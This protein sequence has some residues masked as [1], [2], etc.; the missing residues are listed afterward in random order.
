M[1]HSELLHLGKGGIRCSLSALKSISMAEDSRAWGVLLPQA[2]EGEPAAWHLVVSAIEPNSWPF[3]IRLKVVLEQRVGALAEAASV[4][5]QYA[6]VLLSE[7]SVA[8]FDHAIWYAVVEPTLS[9]EKTEWIERLRA[10]DQEERAA[11]FEELMVEMAHKA[12]E[13]R[14]ALLRA[15]RNAHRSG[16]GG[17]LRTRNVRRTVAFFDR[18]A[19]R[20]GERARAWRREVAERA[21]RAY[22]KYLEKMV[23]DAEQE[24]LIQRSLRGTLADHFPDVV[25]AG[26][27]SRMASYWLHAAGHPIEFGVNR[28]FGLVAEDPAAFGA[29]VAKLRRRA[30]ARDDAPLSVL[31]A[32]HQRDNYLRIEGLESALEI[33]VEYEASPPSSAQGELARV[34]LM[35]KDLQFNAKRHSVQVI[36]RSPDV[37]RGL[38]K[39]AGVGSGGAIKIELEQRL[40][41]N[42]THVR[43]NVHPVAEET[44][45]LSVCHAW[46]KQHPHKVQIVRDAA[47]QR[48]FA[49]TMVETMVESATERVV[50]QLKASSIV[51]QVLTGP[52]DETPWLAGEYLGALVLGVPVVRIRASGRRKKLKLGRDQATIE[53]DEQR[54]DA[55]HEAVSKAL[56]QLSEKLSSLRAGT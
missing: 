5:Q 28:S 41:A 21:N 40:S 56:D 45:F 34:L 6:N 11:A 52:V 1:I 27:L 18:E 23:R 13:L 2:T 35:L 16:E 4:V 19:R 43:V 25:D 50:E 33:S 8:G 29:V 53:F 44:L 42:N 51:L 22:Q 39:F 49:V 15:S 14:V 46:A 12:E 20:L 36:Q 26:W 37:E 31:G 54:D 9:R 30:D 17:F 7:C 38:M 10:P 48:A 47:R 32:F 55:F 3:L 24:P